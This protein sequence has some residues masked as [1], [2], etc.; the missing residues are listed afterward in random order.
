MTEFDKSVLAEAGV[1]FGSFVRWRNPQ[2]R[3][4]IFKKSNRIHI[5]DLQKIV[6][7][8]REVGDYIQSLVEKKKV[9]LFLSTKKTTRDVVREAAIRCGMPYIVNK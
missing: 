7:S 6:T 8:C 9:I 4:Y 1:Q 5:L 2:M 3:P